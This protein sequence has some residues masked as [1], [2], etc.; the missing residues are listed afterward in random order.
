MDKFLQTSLFKTK[1][2]GGINVYR[3]HDVSQYELGNRWRKNPIN[4]LSMLSIDKIQEPDT[5]KVLKS[6]L[7]STWIQGKIRSSLP[8]IYTWFAAT[9]LFIACFIVS[10]SDVHFLEKKHPSNYSLYMCHGLSYINF[11]QSNNT[12]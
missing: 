4:M 8:L 12:K 5:C 3:L 1:L 10:D 7:F 6:P 9:L 2:V 11:A